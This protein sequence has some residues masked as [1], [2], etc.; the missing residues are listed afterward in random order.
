[1]RVTRLAL[2]WVDRLAPRGEPW[3]L[4][5]NYLDPHA[6]Y[7]PPAR[8]RQRFASDVE[9]GSV[10]DDSKLYNSGTLPLTPEVRAAMGALYDGEVAAMDRAFGRLIGGLAERGYG[11]RNLIVIVVSDHGESLGEHGLVGHLLGMNDQLLH[12][13]LLVAGPGIQPGRV[14]A[15]VQS[16]QLRAT[17][18]SLLGLPPLSDIAPPL[19][20]WG[21][22]PSLLI[23][24][25]AQ[26]DWYFGELREVRPDI[27]VRSW[28]GNWVAVERDGTKVV[29][30]DQGRGATYDLQSDPGE[31]A[32]RPLADGAALVEAYQQWRQRNP[33]VEKS[34]PQHRRSLPSLGYVM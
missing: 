3:L 1:M 7:T 28:S 18:R 9:D 8:E 34:A 20:P 27:D 5:V 4:F 25:R 13:P 32:P 23:S 24:E 17:V 19:P 15:P 22:P 30:D 10:A 11:Q 14:A 26:T 31:L 29:F 21:Q 12:V 2:D 16:V 6:P 33:A